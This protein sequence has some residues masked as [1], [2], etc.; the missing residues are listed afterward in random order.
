MRLAVSVVLSVAFM[1]LCGA[2]VVRA[3]EADPAA[4]AR[5]NRGTRTP[6]ERAAMAQVS[7]LPG[8]AAR[9]LALARLVLFVALAVALVGGAILGAGFLIARLL[10][11][12]SG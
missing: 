11:G 7:S 5:S 6:R 3:T 1:G 2:V 9:A 4:R 10:H 8:W 12:S